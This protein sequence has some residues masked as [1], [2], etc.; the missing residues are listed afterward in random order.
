MSIDARGIVSSGLPRVILG[1]AA[2]LVLL[3]VALAVF[4]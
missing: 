3:T 4:R 1:L 2:I